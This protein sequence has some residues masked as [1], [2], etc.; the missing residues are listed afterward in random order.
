[1]LL[2]FDQSP[3]SNALRRQFDAPCFYGRDIKNCREFANHWYGEKLPDIAAVGLS[4]FSD[5]IS[6]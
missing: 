1:M 2:V 6:F 5:S 4:M 3:D